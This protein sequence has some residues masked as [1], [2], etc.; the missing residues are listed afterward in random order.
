MWTD[1][2]CHV[3]SEADPVASLAR[4]FQ[5]GVGT[6]V[7]I[8]TDLDQSRGA[9]ELAERMGVEAHPERPR[10]L[11]TVGLHPHDASVGL[12]SVAALVSDLAS[13]HGGLGSVVAIGECG[14]DYH[15]EHSP[16]H[17]QMDVFAEQVALANRHGLAL[18][19]HTR[20]AWDD[21]FSV[22]AAEGVP[23]RTIFHCF[24]GGPE[25]AERCLDIGAYLS[26][27]GI[28]TFKNADPIRGAAAICPIERVL[29]ETDSPYLTPV[30]HRGRVNEP[31]YL[32][33]V[34]TAVAS[35]CGV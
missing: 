23:E 16:R 35:A 5:A 25:E 19:I 28:I 21:T 1:S 33:L 31:M 9:V 29:V 17:A 34:G 26:F 32:P 3:H 14:L 24:T 12:A 18:V 20:E 27:S 4:A 8:G 2:H 15:Y 10:V 7:C 22:L 11:A 6:V 30:P 13:Q